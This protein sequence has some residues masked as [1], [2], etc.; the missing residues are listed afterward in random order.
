MG[1]RSASARQRCR[2]GQR[3]PVPRRTLVGCGSRHWPCTT[4]RA[5]TLTDT[6][7][8]SGCKEHCARGSEEESRPGRPIPVCG[9]SRV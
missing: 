9:K 2:S 1:L 7:S 3:S 6:S 4:R 5:I 8:P